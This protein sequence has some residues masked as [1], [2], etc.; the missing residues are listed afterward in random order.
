MMEADCAAGRIRFPETT[1][2]AR[3]TPLSSGTKKKRENSGVF[4]IRRC[5]VCREFAAGR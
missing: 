3:I 5:G 1:K 4:E 2:Q